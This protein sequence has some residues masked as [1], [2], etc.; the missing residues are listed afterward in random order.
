MDIDTF[1]AQFADA[2]EV[3]ADQVKADTKFKDLEVWDS[4]CVL[5]IIAMVDS[6]HNVSVGGN[7][8]QNS[9]TVQDV[10]NLVVARAK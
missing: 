10:F 8:L 2:I 3:P 5:N 1:S 7:D 4:L 9:A 6:L